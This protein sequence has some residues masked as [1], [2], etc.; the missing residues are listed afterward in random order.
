MK[1]TV[2][3]EILIALNL[4]YFYE[5]NIFSCII[6]EILFSQVKLLSIC[7]PKL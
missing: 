7:I 6:S 2:Y 3:E 5:T 1:H 4:F